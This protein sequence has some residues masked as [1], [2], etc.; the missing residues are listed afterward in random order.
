MGFDNYGGKGARLAAALTVLSLMAGCAVA[1]QPLEREQVH[2]QAR[3]DLEAALR[4]QE[5]LQGPLTLEEAMARALKYNLDSRLHLMEQAMALGQLDVSHF[6]MLPRIAANAGYAGRSNTSASS[7]ESILTRRQSLEPSTSV[8]TD[9]QV[10][11]LTLVWNVLDFGVG[12]YS[13]KQVADRAL[14]A[15]ERRR[16]VVQ[17]TLQAVAD[18]YWRAV[19]AERLLARIDPLMARVRAAR[20]DSAT[21]EN[22]RLRSPL[23]AL[24]YQRNLVD[25]LSQ[26]ETQRQELA[27]AKIELAALIG[28]PPSRDYQLQA[29]PEGY[30]VPALKVDMEQLEDLALS[31]RPELREEHYQSRISALETRKA[32]LRMLPGIEFSVGGHYDS[33]SYLENHR[34]ADYGAKVTWN[35][36][37]L[38]SGPA[39]L[40]Y[41]EAGE[42]LA[43]S[44]RQALGMAVLTQLYVA[45]AQ[46]EEAQRRFTSARELY[47]IDQRIL[48]QQQA[49]AASQRLGDLTLIQSELNALR[50]TLNQDLLYAE[51]RNAFM[52][53]FWSAGLDPVSGASSESDLASL[54][55][56]L[57]ATQ[58]AW[59]RG[60]LQ[61]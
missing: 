27:R 10:A 11:D 53:V 47:D 15:E 4:G 21:L 20:E 19:A 23:E 17:N 43:E 36:L 40:R 50:S 25:I 39:N 55:Q 56:A 31:L 41:A 51:V 29:P 48:A 57:R 33:N 9:R 22:L 49:G 26:L 46:Y 13:A 59:E 28:L 7:S 18:A 8:D 24:H 37:N 3:Q 35:L 32:L 54:G 6:D 52:R 5:A 44:R 1:P 12:Y 14:I 45:R 2:Q 38:M 42:N 34:W 16:K 60:E 58:A 30:P 61:L